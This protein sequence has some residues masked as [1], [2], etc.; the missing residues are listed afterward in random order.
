VNALPILP[1][2]LGFVLAGAGCSDSPSTEPDS[3]DGLAS[4]PVVR[5]AADPTP[6]TYW[7]GGYELPQ[8]LVVRDQATWDDVWKTLGHGPYLTEQPTVDFARDVLVVVAAG[9]CPNTSYK[10]HVDAAAASS[11]GLTVYVR[12]QW[13]CA[14]GDAIT[15][16][17]DVVR[18]ARTDPVVRFV[19]QRE[20]VCH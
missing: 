9:A 16:P 14:G 17:A 19:E 1:L 20:M 4:V 6:W 5:F 13:G 2:L 15:Y 18:I 10:I 12:T 3:S 11:A 8:R 7:W